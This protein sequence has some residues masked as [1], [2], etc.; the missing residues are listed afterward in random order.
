LLLL[1]PLGS[2]R[3]TLEIVLEAQEGDLEAA[4]EAML[5]MVKDS[6]PPEPAVGGGP[7][8]EV[9]R[10]HPILE[11]DTQIRTDE[12]MARRMQEQIFHE[13][14][15]EQTPTCFSPITGM[16]SGAGAAGYAG[17][18]TGGQTQSQPASLSDTVG[19]VWNAVSA[20]GQQVTQTIVS[21][22]STW[23]AGEEGEK[24]EE[25]RVVQR[26]HQAYMEERESHPVRGG[27]TTSAQTEVHRRKP[28]PPSKKSD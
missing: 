18:R 25:E 5:E 4:I 19:S 28:P 16:L 1:L 24:E 6:E 13:A 17:A 20:M 14:L 2:K 12:M 21:T 27:S 10:Q 11:R 22:A 15:Q 23:M 3:K 7:A 8:F 26:P 9:P